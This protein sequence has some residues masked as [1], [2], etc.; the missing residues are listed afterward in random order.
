MFRLWHE[1]FSLLSVRFTMRIRINKQRLMIFN[2][3]KR[4]T[5]KLKWKKST[6]DKKINSEKKLSTL[7]QDNR[8]DGL[9]G[10]QDWV[11]SHPPQ[12]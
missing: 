1:Y 12:A 8:K 4:S 3:T 9:K 10:F 7:Y 6:V 11:R 5:S 2:K